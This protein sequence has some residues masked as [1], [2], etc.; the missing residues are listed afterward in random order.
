MDKI[1]VTEDQ[2]VKILDWNTLNFE[3]LQDDYIFALN[4][5]SLVVRG[6]DHIVEITDETDTHYYADL[7]VMA[8]GKKIVEIKLEIPK[9][10]TNKVRDIQIAMQ[11]DFGD[12]IKQFVAYSKKID[13]ELTEEKLVNR[14]IVLVINVNN[15]LYHYKKDFVETVTRKYSRHKVFNEAT[16][17]KEPIVYISRTFTLSRK[18]RESEVKR[19]HV[20]KISAWGVRGHKRHYKSGKVIHIKPYVKGKDKSKVQ[21]KTYKIGGNKDA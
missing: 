13:P 17:R 21:G 18:V 5:F 16:G 15:Y 9:Q 20:W 2:C 6:V 7:Q 8:H 3:S 4:K 19:E 1:I 10:A 12:E 11:G 14:L